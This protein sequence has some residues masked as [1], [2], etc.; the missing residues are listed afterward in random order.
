MDIKRRARGVGWIHP[1]GNESLGS[2]KGTDFLE[3]MGDC[4]FLQRILLHGVSWCIC[5]ART[6][7]GSKKAAEL[8]EL[9]SNPW[10]FGHLAYCHSVFR[11]ERGTYQR[12]EAL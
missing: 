1:A 5:V 12:G 2:I 8:I 3:H 10:T 4:N 9:I 6:V 11:K 7:L